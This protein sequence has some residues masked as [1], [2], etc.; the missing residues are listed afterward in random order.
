MTTFKDNEDIPPLIKA[1][2]KIRWIIEDLARELDVDIDG[3]DIKTITHRDDHTGE[4]DIF[5]ISAC[6]INIKE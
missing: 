1:Q 6:I 3:I 2:I 5:D 4:V